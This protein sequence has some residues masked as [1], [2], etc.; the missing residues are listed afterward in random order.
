MVLAIVHFDRQEIKVNEGED[1]NQFEFKLKSKAKVKWL[2]FL[3]HLLIEK[4]S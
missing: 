2:E 3:K 4:S 1:M